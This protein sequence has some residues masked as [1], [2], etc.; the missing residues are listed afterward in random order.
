MIYFSHWGKE[1]GRIAKAHHGA[2]LLRNTINHHYRSYYQ[3]AL[4]VIRDLDKSCLSFWEC[5]CRCLLPGM[6]HWVPDREHTSALF[7]K[8]VFSERTGV[9]FRDVITLGLQPD[10]MK[11]ADAILAWPVIFRQQSCLK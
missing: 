9:R 1:Q 2:R 4:V 3:D 8:I 11:R 10:D 5:L 6:D 7:E